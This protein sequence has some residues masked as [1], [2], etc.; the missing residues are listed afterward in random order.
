MTT[1]LFIAKL[2]GPMFVIVGLALAIREQM[3][4]AIL[5]EFL[6]SPVLLYLAGVFGLLGGLALALVHNVF[7][8]D[9][10]LIITL[11]GWLTIIRALVAIFQPQQI[12]AIGEWILENRAIYFAAAALNLSIGLTLSYFGY[13]V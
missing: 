2:L 6:R 10:R 3:F 13:F 7:A 4:R 9:W 11:V 5:L 12:V 1:S 8:L